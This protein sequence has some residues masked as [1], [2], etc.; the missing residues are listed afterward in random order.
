MAECRDWAATLRRASYRGASFFVEADQVQTGRRLVIHEF[1]HRD[2]PYVEDMGRKANMLTVTAYVV[3]DDVENSAAKLF[4]A[5][6][7]GGQAALNLPTA[8][9]QA[10][11]E[12]CSRDYSKD[13]LGH[14]AF[15]L[16]FVRHGAGSAPFAT[17]GSARSVTFRASGLVTEIDNMFSR[18]F[19]TVGEAG[20]VIDAAIDQVRAF[21][22]DYT[23]ALR[24]ALIDGDALA[25]L[26]V[27]AD[28]LYVGA[29]D[30]TLFGQTG[31]TITERAYL[32]TAE[33][34]IDT[35]LVEA[36]FGLF[37]E[38]QEAL[39]AETAVGFIADW[40]DWADS[41]TV[42]GA[43]PSSER[44]KA[45]AAVITSVVRMSAAAAYVAAIVARDYNDPRIARQA[46]ADSAEILGS[47]LEDFAG[48]EAYE[49]VKEI[50]AL[51]GMVAEHLTNLIATLAPVLVVSAPRRMPSLWWANRL[52]GDA[53]RAD[54]IAK[55]NSVKHASFMPVEF[56]AL[57]R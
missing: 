47:M 42:S 10:H 18:L 19:K 35:G 37:A 40:I 24:L 38:T 53:S 9:L 1:P 4:N 46:R 33:S 26:L 5:C 13:K 52:Y 22:A 44:L 39:D 55:R 11:C 6:Q 29:A 25:G 3:G 56:E 23:S 50:Y 28:D 36:V 20:F 27:K 12:D 8:R 7:S 17:I 41:A 21:S 43:T 16:K 48:W 15:S 51:R 31:D 14:I 32:A 45:N 57:A 49:A 2:T 30:M 54:E 34:S